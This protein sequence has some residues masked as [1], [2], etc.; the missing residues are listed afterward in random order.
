MKIVHFAKF[1]PPEYGGIESVTEALAEDHAAIGHEVEVVCFTR[2]TT[3]FEKLGRLRLRRLKVRKVIASQPLALSYL[4]TCIHAARSADVVHVHSPNML[5]AL[6]VLCLPSN[7]RT[8]IHWHADIENKGIIG[9]LIRPIERAMLRRADAVV[10]T[11]EEYAKASAAL[12]EF[13]D[14]TEVIP[15]GI[16]D[17]KKVPKFEIS[18]V[19]YV[20]FIGRLVPYKGLD[21]LLDALTFIN[22]DAELRIVGIGPE[23]AKLKAHVVRLGLES[24]V[25]FKGRIDEDELEELMAGAAVFCLPSVNRLEAFGVVLLEAMR[26]GRAIVSANIPGSGVPWVNSQ[27]INVPIRDPKALAEAIDQLLEDPLKAKSL[28]ELARARFESEFLRK[29]MSSRFLWL[30]K[31]LLGSAC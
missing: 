1:Y 15:I 18:E 24:K 28:G 6:A 2:E 17:T 22:N 23:L 13:K 11:T 7:V 30:Y 27:G 12:T 5:A 9:T 20:L 29:T 14:K 10:V 25:K 26:A 8:V 3:T 16:A 4:K 31:K 19:P 21:V